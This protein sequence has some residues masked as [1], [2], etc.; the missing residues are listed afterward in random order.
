MSKLQ[1]VAP[2]GLAVTV[3]EFKV[4]DEDLLGDKAAIKNGSVL[5]NLLTAI[6]VSLDAPGPYRFTGSTPD[7]RQ[8]LQGDAMTVI[9]RN[10]IATWP[11]EVYDHKQPCANR[12]C[13]EPVNVGIVME[14]IPVRALPASS[15][16][17]VTQGVPIHALLPRS[18]VKV[19][20]KLL[21]EKDSKDLAKINKDQASHRSSAY[22]RYRLVEVD[23]VPEPKWSE[24]IRDLP[25]ADAAFLRHSFDQADCGLDTTLELHCEAC[26]HTWTE[27][28]VLGTG[29]LFPKYRAKTT[30]G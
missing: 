24:W 13:R 5:A 21:R 20:F 2:S 26:N 18:K 30:T 11:D 6:T 7:W 29:F 15:I 23:G 16:P 22:L 12:V 1:V 9:L 4:E 3:R 19:G 28:V 17:H 27:E 10:R 8:V 25:A 14:Q